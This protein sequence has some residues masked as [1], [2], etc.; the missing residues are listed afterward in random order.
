MAVARR[1]GA[2]SSPGET[3][4]EFVFD[5]SVVWLWRSPRHRICLINPSGTHPLGNT[6]AE[7]I[8][9]AAASPGAALV[10]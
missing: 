5:N 2:G 10:N 6:D 1:N 8:W 4:I 9:H 3:Y 7:T